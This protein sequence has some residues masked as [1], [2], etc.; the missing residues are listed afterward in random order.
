MPTSNY[1]EK[2]TGIKEAWIKNLTESASTLLVTVQLPQVEHTCP[3]C[4]SSTQRIKDYYMRHI[5]HTTIWS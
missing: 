1:I 3:K 4:K 2:L 5:H